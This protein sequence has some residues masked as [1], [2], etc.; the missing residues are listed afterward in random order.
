MKRKKKRTE[1]LKPTKAERI[2][3]D[4][5]LPIVADAALAAPVA[6]GSLVP[7]LIVDTSYRPDIA[8]LIRVHEFL[9]PGDVA[10]QWALVDKQP[11]TVALLLDFVRP[12]HTR[13]VLL[14]SIERQAILV[15]SALTAKAIYLQSG[16]AGD[17]FSQNL[18]QPRILI[19]I[20]PESFRAKWDQVFLERMTTVLRKQNAISRQQADGLA[21]ELIRQLRSITNFRMPRR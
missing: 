17:L 14:F 1:P 10:S 8:E 7:V 15:E 6:E 12:I 19:E 2:P 16:N 13:A 20:P 9:P 3:L 18:D 11:D 5:Q 4:R 21:R